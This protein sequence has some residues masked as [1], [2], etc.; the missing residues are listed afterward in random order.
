MGSFIARAYLLEHSDE[1]KGA[2]FSATA[3]PQFLDDSAIAFLNAIIAKHGYHFRSEKI[4]HILFKTANRH[5]KDAKNDYAWI[6]QRA[7]E[8]VSALMKKLFT[9]TGLRDIAILIKRCNAQS[10]IDKLPKDLPLYFFSGTEDPLGEYG[11]GV[12]RAVK[13]YEKAGMRDV[14][15]RLYE[16][17]RH[18]CLSE[19]NK[20]QVMQDM[21]DWIEKRNQEEKEKCGLD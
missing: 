13:L 3:G 4:Y 17:D 8:F 18:E 1:L 15:L 5:I 12:K 19:N 10:D 21:I 6:S 9:V 14:T 16:G 2:I 11:E 7:E 20:E